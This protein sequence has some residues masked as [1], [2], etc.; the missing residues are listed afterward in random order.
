MCVCVKQYVYL[1]VLSFVCRGVDMCIDVTYIYIYIYICMCMRV[2][3]LFPETS[4][5]TTNEAAGRRA[6]AIHEAPT[7]GE[8]SEGG[9]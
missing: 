8:G 1:H 2:H 9:V 3:V 5:R 4:A 7:G 6:H